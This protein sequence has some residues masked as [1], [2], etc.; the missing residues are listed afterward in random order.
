MLSVLT[1]FLFVLGVNNTNAC[2]IVNFILV[3]IYN[4]VHVQ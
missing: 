2:V 1:L 3:R 4:I